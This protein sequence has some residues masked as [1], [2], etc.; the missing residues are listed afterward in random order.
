MT[1][2][3]DSVAGVRGDGL[4]AALSDPLRLAAVAA[5]GLL[6]TG[7]EE[8][9]E[10]LASLAARVTGSGRAFV[11]LVDGER[12]FWKSCVGVDAT[13][14]ADRQNPVRE[15]FCYFLVGLGGEPFVVHDAAG[16]PR[17]R[18]HPSV[19]PMRIGAWAG[20]PLLA[21][22]GEVLGSF[23]VID[24]SPRIWSDA[25]LTTLETLA[26]SVSA[27]I[28]L[29][30]SLESARQA[31]RVSARLAHSLQQGLLPPALHAIPGLETAASYL[32]A[33]AGGVTGVEV[34][35]DFYDL[36]P[37]RGASFA[38]V[39]GDV[40]GKGVEA[41]KVTA[42]ARYTVRAIASRAPSPAALLGELNT[43]M[44][45][46]HAPR[47]L[48][49]AY[50]AFRLTPAGLAGRI[51]LAG[52]PPALVR[53]ADGRVHRLGAPG[54]LLGVVPD[55]RLAD[56][57]FRLAPGDLLLLYTDG[58]CEARP[59]PGSPLGSAQ[60]VFGEDELAAALAGT[61]GLDAETTVKEIC[62]A[63][64]AHHGGWASD[65]TALLALRVPP[66]S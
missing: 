23:C 32:P 9:F 30:Q 18:D 33:S 45:T 55:V 41:A 8:V 65:D 15:S 42:M 2:D 62:G 6:D 4:P 26:R 14:A 38:A 20:F 46:Q 13:A 44:L 57:R 10:D 7:P 61:R 52:H 59:R 21:P 35:G 29:R 58:A 16:D 53:R 63:L 51:S 1:V 25:D 31:H 27:E 22:G 5:T 39:L 24:D 17:T 48:T 60:P 3:L 37:T 64:A 36:F 54:T 40:C 34:G 12:S 66:S 28:H 47:F 50:T 19:G 49:A 11:T 43:A 56:V